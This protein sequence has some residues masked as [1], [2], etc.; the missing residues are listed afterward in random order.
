MAKTNAQA[1][2]ENRGIERLVETKR[3]IDT[4]NKENKKSVVVLRLINEDTLS[5]AFQIHFRFKDKFVDTSIYDRG[6]A[7]IYPSEE[8]YKEI[9]RIAGKQEVNW[10]N[11][12]SIGW[13][14]F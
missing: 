10:N 8:V 5:A 13:L 9:K 12:A 2:L 14:S 3:I 4:F 7:V 11:T 1:E 6:N